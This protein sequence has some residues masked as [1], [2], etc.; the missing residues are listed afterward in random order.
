[1]HHQNRRRYSREFKLESL[2]QIDE[3]GKTIAQ[4]A[5]ELDISVH[6]LYDWRRQFSNK[7][8][9][10]FPGQGKTDPKDEL[11]R[12]RKENAQ[13]REERDILKKS[14]IFFAKEASESTASSMNIETNSK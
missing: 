2:R 7:G 1:M 9:N 13:L 4:V 12:L 8:Q 6:Q 10:A 3:S 14:L 5:R 11:A